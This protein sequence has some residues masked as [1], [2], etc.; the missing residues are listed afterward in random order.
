MSSL[1]DAKIIEV[2][3]PPKDDVMPQTESS[4]LGNNFT[5]C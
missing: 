2:T 1:E 4:P 3:N 5:L